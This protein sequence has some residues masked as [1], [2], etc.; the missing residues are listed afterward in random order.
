MSCCRH[1]EAIQSRG[2]VVEKP[3]ERRAIKDRGRD[4][5]LVTATDLT[6]IFSHAL[7][8]FL[9]AFPSLTLTVAC[10]SV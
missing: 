10:V 5:G 4:E 2:E 8:T 6:L 7:S 3:T 9:L 1:K